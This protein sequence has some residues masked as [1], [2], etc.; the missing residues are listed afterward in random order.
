MS[1]LFSW[2]KTGTPGWDIRGRLGTSANRVV[3]VGRTRMGGD[4]VCI[5]G[6]DLDHDFRSVRLLDADGWNWSSKAPFNPGE[7][8]S[9]RYSEKATEPPHV[10]DVLV[11]TQR[12]HTRVADLASLVLSHVQPW[13]GNPEALFDGT[14]RSTYSG[15]ALIPASGALP[16]CSTG[17]WLPA[18]PLMYYIERDKPRFRYS[19]RGAI[20]RFTWVGVQ[21]PPDRIEA[22]SLVRV[23]LSRLFSR[24]RVTPGY[25]VQISGVL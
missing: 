17:Y 8:W 14:V 18:D 24:S 15:I 2:R 23:S 1:S 9:I 22:G 19:S 11:R 3:I 4:H 13:E 16:R 5:G 6:H 25:Y 10:E 20:N 7:V 21:D 12:R